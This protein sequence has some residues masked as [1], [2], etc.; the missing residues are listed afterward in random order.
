MKVSLTSLSSRG[1]ELLIGSPAIAGLMLDAMDSSLAQS[2]GCQGEIQVLALLLEGGG[3]S[4]RW[5]EDKNTDISGPLPTER[6]KVTCIT[7]SQNVFRK[8]KWCF[9]HRWEL[10]T[11]SDIWRNDLLCLV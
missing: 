10:Q 7:K 5:S 2:L 4:D 1:A 6:A 3:E 11:F 8:T 9:N